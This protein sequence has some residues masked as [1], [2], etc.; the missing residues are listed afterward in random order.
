MCKIHNI[1]RTHKLTKLSVCIA[2]AFATMFSYAE[3]NKQTNIEQLETVNVTSE[4]TKA[5]VEKK[6]HQKIQQELIRDTKDLVRYS[7]DVGVAD[8]GRHLKGFAMRGV[9]GNRVGIS[10][11]G[12]NIPDFEENSLYKRYGNFNNSRLSIDSE[13]VRSI[14]SIKGSDSFNSG[15]GALGGTVNYRTLEARDV[16]SHEQGFGGLTRLGYAGKNSEWVKT[17]GVGYVGEKIEALLMYSQRDGNQTKSAGGNITPQPK[18][19]YDS[20][21]RTLQNA[22]VGAS[23]IEPDP[24]NHTFRSYLAKLGWAI[25]PQHK[26]GVSLIGQ[27]NRRFTNELSYVSPT[28][29]RYYRDA[30]DRQKL[31]NSNMFYAWKIQK[32]YIDVAR[33]DYDYQTTE[34]GTINYKGEREGSYLSGYDL[35]TKTL[36]DI[37]FR[38]AK[39]KLQRLSLSLDTQPF[40]LGGEHLLEFK[41]YGSKRTFENLNDDLKLS[42]NVH[43]IYT[44]QRPTTTI[45]KGMSVQNNTFWNEMFSSVLGIRYDHTKITPKAFN[46]RCSYNCVKAE[47]EQPAHETTFANWSGK[48][49]LEARLNDIWKTGYGFSTGFRVPTASEL[50]FQYNS[51]S[52]AWKANP[53]LKSER[54]VNHNVFVQANH[55]LGTFD[56]NVYHSKYKNF[57]FE[58][59]AIGTFFNELC[60]PPYLGLYCSQTSKIPSQQMVNIDKAR[61]SGLELKTNLNLHEVSPL[62]EGL[63]TSF[64]L[65]YSKGKLSINDSLLSIQPLKLIFGFDY[66]AP[67]GKWGVFTRTTYQRGKKGSDAKYTEKSIDV[68]YEC[69]G[70]SYYGQCYGTE[71]KHE[72]EV[73]EQLEWRWL[74]KSYW[75]FDMFGYYNPTQNITLRAGVYNLFNAKYHTWDTLRGI[76]IRGTTDKVDHT[77]NNQGLQRFYAPGRNFSGSIEY[78]F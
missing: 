36:T 52:G 75:V 35:N 16:V 25:N 4:N 70:F 41:V 72:T 21:A 76:N 62:P 51:A 40:S 65:G 45:Q 67:S 1:Q 53:N 20:E 54:S 23:R 13:F 49:E 61:I 5:G 38:N 18:S 69:Q 14:E 22:L 77:H 47:Q 68:S 7:T 24:S 56:L 17:A 34:N 10:I 55:D 29:E 3:T 39:T 32:P 2:T 73:S 9:E 37:D 59:E 6:N 11:D 33:L 19:Q 46:A 71:I 8:N 12:I 31:L 28:T 66:E 26:V 58:Q 60:Q 74:N 43:N 48:F 78:R 30:D 50:Y 44:I 63:K 15:S 42:N 57:L 27:N 64:A